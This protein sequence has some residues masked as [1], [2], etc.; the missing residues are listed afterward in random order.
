MPADP[1]I[2]AGLNTT[3]MMLSHLCN[4]LKVYKINVKKFGLKWLGCK[5]GKKQDC[6]EDQLDIFLKRI[7]YYREDPVYD[8]GTVKGANSIT[9][10]LTDSLDLVNAILDHAVIQRKMAWDIRPDYTGDLY[11]HLIEKMECAEFFFET[12]LNIIK[13]KDEASYVYARLE[14]E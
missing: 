7:F 10:V 6:V 12:Q 13:L 8:I 11:E 14:D 3:C 5:L 4:Q 9:E 1:Q 2:I